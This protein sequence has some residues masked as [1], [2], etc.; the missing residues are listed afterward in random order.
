MN[1]LGKLWAQAR[2]E[3]DENAR[4]RAGV[5]ASGALALFYVLL[6]Q[7]ERSSAAYE[8]YAAEAARLQKA[9]ALVS[10]E[11]WSERL[12]A[13]RA[14]NRELE[15]AFWQA[16]TEGLAQARLQAALATLAEGRNLREVRVLS[17]ITQPVHDV[18][19]LWQVQ[20][21]FSATYGRGAELETLHALATH[22][23]KLVVERLDLKRGDKRM[24]MVLSAYF[25]GLR[26]TASVQYAD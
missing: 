16:E 18:D 4:L 14:V 15:S 2:A 19:G 21:Q 22:P 20:A 17:G 13:E 1:A 26:D 23:R 11:D 10:A 24:S 3:L 25:A 9:E 7:F 8:D 12:A 6:V 5:W